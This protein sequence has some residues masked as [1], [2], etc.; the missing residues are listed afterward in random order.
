MASGNFFSCG[1]QRVI[2]SGQDSVILT[3]SG[4]SHIINTLIANSN[5]S[6]CCCRDVYFFSSAVSFHDDSYETSEFNSPYA[7]RTPKV[8]NNR[9]KR[10]K[11]PGRY[12]VLVIR[13]VLTVRSVCRNVKWFLN[14][15]ITA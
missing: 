15:V 7:D 11:K 5:D 9:N 4:A 1:T 14:L 8:D 13:T 2:L 10:K 12:E 6:S 3:A